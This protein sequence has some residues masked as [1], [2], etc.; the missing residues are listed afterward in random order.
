MADYH[1]AAVAHPLL[2]PLERADEQV[3]KLGH[4]LEVT[5]SVA[6]S[7]RRGRPPGRDPI[8]ALGLG[9][10]RVVK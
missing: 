8:S 3:R 5:P 2:R 6:S 7:T 10:L 4:E 9:G 1:G